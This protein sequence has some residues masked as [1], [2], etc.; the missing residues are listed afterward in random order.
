MPGNG[1]GYG[2]LRHRDPGSTAELA[3]YGRPQLGFNYLG[4]YAAPELADWAPAPEAPALGAGFDGTAPLGLGIELDAV[5]VD[6]TRGAQ[7][8][9]TW[10]WSKALLAE[11]DVRELAHGWFASLADLAAVEGGGLTRPTCPSW[12]FRKATSRRWKGHCRTWSTCCRSPRSRRACSFTLC[13]TP[14][15]TSTPSRRSSR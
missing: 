12:T 4:R 11:D 6:H 14:A 1:L 10:T 9:A 13:T 15:P 7:L 3:A 2:L 8:V 5:I